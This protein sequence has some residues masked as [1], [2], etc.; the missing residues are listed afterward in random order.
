MPKKS[1]NHCAHPGCYTFG[2]IKRGG[3][4]RKHHPES[5]REYI[6]KDG[7]YGY[8]F[9]QGEFLPDKFGIVKDKFGYEDV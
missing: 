4:C 8:G 5:R 1:V 9:H 7:Y 2:S 3:Y 6:I